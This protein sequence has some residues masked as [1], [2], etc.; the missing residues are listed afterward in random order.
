M[1][2]DK[3]D[4]RYVYHFNLPEGPRVVLAGD[5]P[6]RPRRR[7]EHLRAVRVPRRRPD[8]RELRLRRHAD[9]RGASPPCSTRSSPTT[10][11]QQFAVAEYEL[12]ARYD[13]R[14]LVLKTILTYLELDG[15]L[16][17][18]TPF[19]AGYSLRPTTGELDDVFAG[20]RPGA[21]RL[22]APR[23]RDRQDEPNLDEHRP[24]A[25]SRR[26][27]RGAK[28]DRR[29]ARLPRAAAPRR[30]EA[31]RR[32]PALHRA[33]APRLAR[34]R[35]RPPGRALRPARAGRDR[36]DPARRLARHP[37]GLPGRGARR[38]LRRD[39]RGALRPLQLLPRRRGAASTRAGGAARAR[40]GRRRE[41]R[42]ARS[43]AANPEALREPRQR[44]RFLCGLTSPATTRAKL[45]R[46]PLFGAAADHRFAEVLDW[47]ER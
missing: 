40:H 2:I 46:D 23:R 9:A 24:R 41:P 6:R 21:R 17:Q 36:A 7:A 11:G 14:T 4:V 27:R 5:R 32:P 16:R 1:G 37:R 35:G 33:R 22:P 26:A 8:A 10:S 15:F 42:S 31:G 25:G 43:R 47:C 38:L 28:P 3:A 13:V 39:A 29:R 45:T 44:A 20:V 12:S 19:Y 30:A 18:G 34:R